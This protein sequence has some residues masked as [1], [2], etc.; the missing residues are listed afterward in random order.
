MTVNDYQ[1]TFV[2][3]MHL[4]PCGA[5]ISHVSQHQKDKLIDNFWG[6]I[7]IFK[8]LALC[9]WLRFHYSNID[10]VLQKMNWSLF[11]NSAVLTGLNSC[12]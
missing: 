3:K 8:Y 2:E 4:I 10:F 7:I 5:K 1:N 11:C 12:N 9:T 6:P